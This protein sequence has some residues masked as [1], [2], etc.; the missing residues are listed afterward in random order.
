MLFTKS[1]FLDG[2]DIPT[3]SHEDIKKQLNKTAKTKK[4]SKS[5]NIDKMP[6][7][8]KLDYIESEVNRILGR[9]KGFIKVISSENEFAEYIDKCID[10]GEAAFDTETNNSLDPLT[11]KI[12]GLCFYIENTRPVYVPI[13]HAKPGT[14]E[15]LENQVSEK[16]AKEQLQ[17]LADSGTKLI[18]HNGKF[19]IRVVRNTLGVTLPIW[20]DTMIAAQLLDE[21]ELARLKYQFKRHINPTIDS[22]SIDK[23][24]SG[25]SYAWV[26]P[27]VF[28]IYA[29]IDTYD[30]LLL[31]RWQQS[32][33][34]QD[35]LKKLYNLFMSIEMPIVSVVSKMEDTGVCM[36]TKFVSRLNDKYENMLSK[37]K[38]ELDG[39]LK[40][41]E[42]KVQYYQENGTLDI[43]INYDS[44]AQLSIVL[45]DIMGTPDNG[46]KKTDK[47]ALKSM[48]TPF[49]NLLLDY[50]H[51]S[52]LISG[53]TEPL[54]KML[55]TRDNKIHANFNQMGKED[56]SVRTGRFSSTDPNLQQIP[57][58]EQ[59]MRLMFEAGEGKC[60]VGGDFSA[61]EP[62]ILVHLSG[63][64]ILRKTFEEKRDPYATISSFVFGKSY[65]ECMEHHEDG[66][67][68]PEGKK[69]RSKAKKIM[70]G[71][72]YGM[73]AKLMST[74]LGVSIDE[75]KE[76]LN[77]FFEMFPDVKKFTAYNEKH[78][79]EFGFV[80]DYMGRRRHLPNAQLDELVINAKKSIM[81][82][83]DVFVECNHEDVMI[84]IPDDE[85]TALW[86]NRW[87]EF[88]K[89]TKYRAK[90]EFKKIA[91]DSGIDYEDNGGFISKSITQCTNARVQGS[92]ATLT[93]KAMII[94][95]SDEEMKRLGF[96]LLIPIHDELLGE[97]PIENAEKVE[98][99]LAELMVSSA[100]PECNVPMSCD[101]YCVKHWYA[102]EV[103]NTIRERFIEETGAGK[104]E[105][106]V[107]NTICDDYNELSK[108]VVKQMC[109]GT[110]DLLTEV[111]C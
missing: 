79:K 59:V 1:S 85:L 40:P 20:W 86:T 68:N 17:K 57:S 11:C 21:N 31:Q 47:D 81:T 72:L 99:R 19:D 67:P 107:Y 75:C 83:A 110:F 109:Y 84:E 90:D 7:S 37:I 55:S 52:K 44:P 82:K 58:K 69:I 15:L 89:T 48:K 27:E 91:K 24:F 34:E 88:Q 78:A 13:N 33:F 39:M 12:M 101:T 61:Q 105:E 30:T 28:G 87:K 2:F 38:N 56:N 108:E 95:D 80:E 4:V 36:D 14:D 103:S 97:C 73:G 60:F 22:Y 45:Y 65:W 49:S 76:I 64:Q 43:P 51:Y 10:K 70:L 35:D 32:V 25:V 46:G 53:F 106:D 74:N 26:N 66:S 96:Q 8:E 5:V 102:D 18:Y 6:L 23:L 29:A 54:P 9:Y 63:E 94:I 98:K 16:F 41:Y 104:N 93:K 92:A 50:R 42:S 111:I 77:Q 71:I 100:K 62:R 3:V